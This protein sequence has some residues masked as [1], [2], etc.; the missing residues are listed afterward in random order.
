MW[1]FQ[2]FLV[3][4]CVTDELGR[5]VGG[6]WTHHPI[7]QLLPTPKVNRRRSP[8][9][10]LPQ[11]EGWELAFWGNLCAQAGGKQK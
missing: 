6:A 1:H 4:A 9:A 11:V 8:D 3:G 10:T 7:T 5:G 2:C